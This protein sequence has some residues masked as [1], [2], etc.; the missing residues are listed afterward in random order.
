LAFFEADVISA[1][2]AEGD[3]VDDDDDEAEEDDEDEEDEEDGA[4]RFITLTYKQKK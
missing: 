1:N 2:T 3:D 4:F